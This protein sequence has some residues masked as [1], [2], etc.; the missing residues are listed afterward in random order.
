MNHIRPEPSVLKVTIRT[1]I[2]KTH[3]LQHVPWTNMLLIYTTPTANTI[4]FLQLTPL[5]C[6]NDDKWQ[7]VIIRTIFPLYRLKFSFKL[8]LRTM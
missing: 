4:N 7:L 8:T 5:F 2:H 6:Q 1:H 3:L